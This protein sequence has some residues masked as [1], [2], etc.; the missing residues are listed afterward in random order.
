MSHDISVDPG[1]EAAERPWIAELIPGE[2][3]LLIL[4]PSVEVPSEDVV[5][6]LRIQAYERRDAPTMGTHET[7]E[8]LQTVAGW[9]ASGVVGNAAFALFPATWAFA[10]R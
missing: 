1:A 4:D 7:V 3:I 5:E 10:R 9:A 8:A 6:E 2:D